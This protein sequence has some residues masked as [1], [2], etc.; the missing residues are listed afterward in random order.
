MTETGCRRAAPSS[1]HPAGA[2][3]A[4]SSLRPRQPAAL[5]TFLALAF[6]WTWGLWLV[7]AALK[8]RTPSLSTAMFI[9]SGFGPSL[10]GLIVVW[11]FEGGS[12]VRLWLRRCLAWRMHR[13][14]HALAFFGPPLAIAAALGIHAALGGTVPPMSANGHIGLTMVQFGLILFIGG[15]VGEEF[16]WRGYALPQL[17]THLGWRW[18]SLILGAIWGLWHLPLFFIPGMV[19]A[20][21]PMALFLASNVAMSVVMARMS[22]TARFSVLPAIVFHWSI[23]AW[24]EFLP[25]IPNGGSER[26]YVL[27]MGI[28]FV[29]AAIV[30]LKPGPHPSQRSLR[31]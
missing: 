13:V 12:G 18:A 11:A 26:P 24:A 30:F 29:T 14:L 2:N 28:L 7:G 17:A 19:Q 8:L 20:Q 6:G 1:P 22:V 21:M 4:T 16:G 31:K 3:A 25:I 10:A 5:L 15:P 23:N 27:V 9:L